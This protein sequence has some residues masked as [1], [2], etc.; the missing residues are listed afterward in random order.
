[1]SIEF[2]DERD[3]MVSGGSDKQIKIWCVHTGR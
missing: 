2:V 1:M 3:V